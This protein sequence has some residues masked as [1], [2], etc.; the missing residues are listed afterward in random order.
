MAIALPMPLE[1]PVI[2]AVF[3]DNNPIDLVQFFSY[4]LPK[5]RDLFPKTIKEAP[6]GANPP[7][8][9]GHYAAQNDVF[10]MI[11]YFKPNFVLNIKMINL[12]RLLTIILVKDHYN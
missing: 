9:N 4:K 12:R 7:G 10:C 8:Q 11:G 3:P 6:A 5:N 1:A 2:R